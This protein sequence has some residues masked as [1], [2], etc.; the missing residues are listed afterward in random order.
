MQ[1]IKGD[2]KEDHQKPLFS[3]IKKTRTWADWIMSQCLV[4]NW[5]N[6]RQQGREHDD[7]EAPEEKKRSSHVNKL[8]PNPPM[9]M[10]G[11]TH[12]LLASLLCISKCVKHRNEVMY[13]Y[14]LLLLYIRILS[15]FALSMFLVS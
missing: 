7:E 11:I 2:A 8:L 13:V 5:N 3:P 10:Y 9:P 4:P 12:L 14:C 15:F 6:V 1:E